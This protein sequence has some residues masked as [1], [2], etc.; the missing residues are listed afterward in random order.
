MTKTKS[1][2]L[3]RGMALLLAV[4]MC[5]SLLSAAVFAEDAQ[6]PQQQLEALLDEIYALDPNDYT[7]ESWNE[8]KE[9]AD[10]VNRPVTPYDEATGEGMPDALVPVGSQKTVYEQL[11]EKL[12]EAEALDPDKYT[13]ES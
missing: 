7:E 1:H 6:T 8:L 9:T 10:S 5:V 12:Q 11:E 2:W 4:L 3:Q 13:A